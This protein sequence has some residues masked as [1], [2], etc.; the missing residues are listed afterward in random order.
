MSAGQPDALVC[1]PRYF[2]STTVTEWPRRDRA[3]GNALQTSARP[4]VFAKGR[5]SDVTNRMFSASLSRGVL[6]ARDPLLARGVLVARE[7]IF[8]REVLVARGAL[9]AREVLVARGAI[10]APEVL[11]VLGVLGGAG[12]LRRA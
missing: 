5:A 1:A 8:A 10:F 9:F 3:R 7:A 11:T 12:A 2:G 6:F 4:P